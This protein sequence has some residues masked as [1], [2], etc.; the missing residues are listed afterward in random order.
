MDHLTQSFPAT[1]QTGKKIL[2]VSP[3]W[4]EDHRWMISSVKLSELWQRMGY[5]VTVVCMGSKNHIEKISD[6]LTVHFRKDIF[7]PDPFN[8]GIAFGF[9]RY[10][11]A[12]ADDMKP[13]LVIVNKVLFWSSL[14]I[15]RL[16]RKGYSALL[17]TDALVGITWKPRHWYSKIIMACGAWTVGR[18][19]LHAASRIVFFHPQPSDVLQ[20]LKIDQQSTVI[21]TGID[22]SLFHADQSMIDQAIHIT[23][24]GRLESVKGVDDF[25]EAA[26]CI[27][28]KYPEIVIQVVGWYKDRHDLVA[29]YESSVIFTGLSNDIPGIL[30]GTDIF[31]LPSHSEGLSNALMEAMASGCACIATN[32]G[33]NAFLIE[34]EKSGLLFT[35]G[36][37]KVLQMHMETL[38]DDGAYRLWLGTAA[39]HRIE[40]QFSW[41]IVSKQ[42]RNIFEKMMDR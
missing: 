20:K 38:I 21:P 4:L 28:E 34:H 35:P 1:L 33:G 37:R 2:L 8:Y 7:L 42:Y 36:D 11:A 15:F 12:V 19:V 41:E 18:M 29:K 13:D 14:A 23:Y 10:V 30:R 27:K 6:T 26:Q 24:V 9:S 3:Y 5:S 40:E 22:P 39:R 31:V 32:V 16:K 25:L 17:I